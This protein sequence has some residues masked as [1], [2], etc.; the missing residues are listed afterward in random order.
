MAK[1]NN[2]NSKKKATNNAA[3][4]KQ[5]TGKKKHNPFDSAFKQGMGYPG[6]AEDLFKLYLPDTIKRLINF[7]TIEKK[8]DNFV[9]FGFQQFYSDCLFGAHTKGK[10]GYLYLLVEQQRQPDKQ[11]LLRIYTYVLR[12]IEKHLKSGSKYF[13]MVFPLIYYNGTKTPYPYPID[14][15][16]CFKTPALAKELMTRPVELVDSRTLPKERPPHSWS[17]F[18]E[19]LLRYI[20]DKEDF[21][22]I[23]GGLAKSGNINYIYNKGENGQQYIKSMLELALEETTINDE[24]VLYNTLQGHIPEMEEN[25]MGLLKK[26]HEEGLAEG[27]AYA[28]KLSQK[29]HEEGL[30]EGKAEE[31][32]AIAVTMLEKGFSI[33]DVFGITGL[34]TRLL[35]RL[36]RRLP[37]ET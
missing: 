12:I 17:N 21:T 16:S 18:M 25:V 29:K 20:R 3:D 28:M 10:K 31:K 2:P 4:D 32:E 36:Q 5:E 23:L 26:K 1:K 9:D 19:L 34:S 27:K 37:A 13:P 11:F 30:A 15:W 22:P 35:K 8:S 24:T 6:V 7:S 14:F 33:N